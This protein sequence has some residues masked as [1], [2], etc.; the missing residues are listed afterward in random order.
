MTFYHAF[1]SFQI[2]LFLHNFTFIYFFKWGKSCS[3]K[4]M[5]KHS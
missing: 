2:M 5:S 3:D 4:V 1:E